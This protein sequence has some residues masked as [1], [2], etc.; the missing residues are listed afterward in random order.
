[1]RAI[2][3]LVRHQ[4]T[5]TDLC[6]AVFEYFVVLGDGFF[7]DPMN[8]TIADLVDIDVA[9]EFSDLRTAYAYP[10]DATQWS[11]GERGVYCFVYSEGGDVF[12]Q[13]LR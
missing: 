5:S 13:S 6:A 4:I 2:F 9:R 10:V 12:T 11:A 7:R 3:T 8:D 1:M